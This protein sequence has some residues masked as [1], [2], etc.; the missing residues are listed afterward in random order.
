MKMSY[1]NQSAIRI[2]QQYLFLT[3]KLLEQHSDLGHHQIET[4][5]DF[6]ERIPY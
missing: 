2:V 4:G 6:E 5:K 3:L 1:I